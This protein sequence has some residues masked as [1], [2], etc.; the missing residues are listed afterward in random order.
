MH[1]R[2]VLA[3]GKLLRKRYAGRPGISSDGKELLI[4]LSPKEHP[5]TQRFDP[6]KD[7]AGTKRSTIAFVYFRHAR[8]YFS[9]RKTPRIR[10]SRMS[11]LSLLLLSDDAALNVTRSEFNAAR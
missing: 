10:T 2:S 1:G 8:A 4:L 9:K 3:A 5:S 7:V 6:E 11:F